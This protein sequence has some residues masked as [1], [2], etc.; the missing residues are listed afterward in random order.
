MDFL[1]ESRDSDPIIVRRVSYSIL[2]EKPA[3]IIDSE[4]GVRLYRVFTAP[5]IRYNAPGFSSYDRMMANPVD[6]WA[7]E[8]LDTY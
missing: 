3:V 8:H 1:Y 2:D 7:K 4:T 6:R 5:Q